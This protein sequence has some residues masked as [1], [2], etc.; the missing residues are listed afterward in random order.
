[1]KADGLMYEQKRAQRKDRDS[2][3][4]VA[5]NAATDSGN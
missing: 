4:P 5:T 2:S 3:K 1:V